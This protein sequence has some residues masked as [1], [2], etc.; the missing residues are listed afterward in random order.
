M[1]TFEGVAMTTPILPPR[2]PGVAHA[3]ARRLARRIVERQLQAQGLYPKRMRYADIM[4]L[5]M[6]YL[7]K[8]QELLDQA[9]ETVRNDPRFRTLLEREERRARRNVR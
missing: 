7:R 4:A 2:Y 3:L 5:A 1:T 8:H 9:A 6:E